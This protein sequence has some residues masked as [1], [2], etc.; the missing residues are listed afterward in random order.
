MTNL[1]REQW[2]EV[3]LEMVRAEKEVLATMGKEEARGFT[4][5]RYLVEVTHL[6]KMTGEESAKIREVEN[7]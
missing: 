2:L 4:N 3:V 1:T 5:A 7:S 6:P